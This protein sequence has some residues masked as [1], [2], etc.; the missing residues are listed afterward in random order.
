MYLQHKGCR[1]NS[2][3]T[4]YTLDIKDFLLMFTDLTPRTS[5]I[6]ISILQNKKSKAQRGWITC[7]RSF[8][9]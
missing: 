3:Y 6:I 8:N 5:P 1:A 9:Y 2:Y 7:P 4:Y